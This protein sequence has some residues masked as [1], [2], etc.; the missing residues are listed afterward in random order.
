[1]NDF[2]LKPCP[3]CGTDNCLSMTVTETLTGIYKGDKSYH[4]HCIPCGNFTQFCD[5]DS[6][7]QLIE[8]WNTRN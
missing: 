6:K 8:K 3:F 7:E 1:M 2:G 4:I 5:T